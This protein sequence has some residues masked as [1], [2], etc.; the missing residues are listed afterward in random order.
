MKLTA[1]LPFQLSGRVLGDA[2]ARVR[3]HTFWKRLDFIVPTASDNDAPV[4]MRWNAAYDERHGSPITYVNREEW[5][6]FPVDGQQTVR[7]HNGG[8]WRQCMRH[9]L[10][11]GELASPVLD[12]NS[13]EEM[14]SYPSRNNLI[15]EHML[16]SVS[17]GKPV[18]DN[19]TEILGIVDKDHH[20]SRAIDIELKLEKLSNRLL[21][22]DDTVFI[23]CA[24][25]K[26][27][28]SDCARMDRSEKVVRLIRI[29]TDATE[30]E[31]LE[32]KRPDLV[33]PA[34]EFDQALEASADE[35]YDPAL[36]V[37][38]N[39]PRRP[40]VVRA[41]LLPDMDTE[42]F[43]AVAAL[44]RFH[45]FGFEM[46]MTQFDGPCRD[47]H[48][49]LGSALRVFYTT[50]PTVDTEGL[51]LAL[52]QCETAFEREYHGSLLREARSHFDS[53]QIGFG[54]RIRGLRP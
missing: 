51:E 2:R 42:T 15:G 54:D 11:G 48:Q 20:W 24:E 19:E 49:A 22:V 7:F 35:G 33:F 31:A 21:V 14:F 47:A 6:V 10:V 5:G 45:D 4:V 16:P 38:F 36:V 46:E 30:I 53:S 23:A 40:T 50:L 25:P 12:V 9:D 3:T 27:V 1:I 39:E 43:R 13:L 34:T 44:R 8:Y 28:L 52:E 26:I 37:E 32:R 17:R 18:V 29:E 41:D